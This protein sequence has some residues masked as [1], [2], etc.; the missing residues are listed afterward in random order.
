MPKLVTPDDRERKR[1]AILDAAAEIA[2]HGYDRA[3][4]NTIAVRLRREMPKG[5]RV[6]VIAHGG[7]AEIMAS[8]ASIFDM[9]RQ[10]CC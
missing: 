10:I 7:L 4:I 8:T 5:M 1:R 6:I 3:N 9:R 2:R